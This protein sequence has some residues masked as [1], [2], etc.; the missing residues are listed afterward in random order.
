VEFIPDEGAGAVV[1]NVLDYAKYLRVMMNEE[2]PFS[3]DGHRE[4]KTGRSFYAGS[5]PFFVGPITYTLGW[6]S[7]IF[8]GEQ[9]WLH[10]GQINQ[11]TTWMLMVPS[12]MIGI[13]VMTNS[14]SK[15]MTL[16]LY[17]ILYDLFGVE[18]NDRFDFVTKYDPPFYQAI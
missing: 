8:Q 17:R 11:F 9:I 2:G 16:V 10:S 14:A 4:L 7:A 13:T 3:K 1:S 15:S 12:K 5:V 18:E 6:M